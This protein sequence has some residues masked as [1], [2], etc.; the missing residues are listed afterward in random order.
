[1]QYLIRFHFSL[2]MTKSSETK[3]RFLSLRSYFLDRK[4]RPVCH[5]IGGRVRSSFLLGQWVEKLSIQF[6]AKDLDRKDVVGTSDPFLR[7]YKSNEDNRHKLIGYFTA[8]LEQL[9][10]GAKFECE[11]PNKEG[12]KHSGDRVNSKEYGQQL[13]NHESQH[14]FQP[15]EQTSENQMNGVLWAWVLKKAW[16]NINNLI[17]VDFT[18]SNG[19][20]GDPK[21][22]HYANPNSPNAYVQALRGVGEV[23]ELYDS[24]GMFPAWGF[25]ARLPPDGAISHCF[26]LNEHISNP[27]CIK[28]DGVLEAYYQTL[29]RTHADGSEYFI[30]LILTDGMFCDIDNT[31]KA[32]VA[33]SS[34]PLSIII[35]GIGDAD[36]EGMK[37][38]DGDKQRFSFQGKEAEGDIV[39]FFKFDEFEKVKNVR[40]IDEYK[41]ILAAEVLA[42]VPGQF[43]SYMER[44][45]VRPG[46]F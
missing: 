18:E 25:G 32:I 29:A 24:D 17:A 3:S 34:L 26:P 20:P 44:N 28:I 23:I 27:Y 38:L 45:K 2:T 16:T 6:C 8:S 14:E 46:Q 36:F 4:L 22:L 15:L 30:L 19:K 7:I 31:S 39:Q 42:E 12:K 40:S 33:A 35:I 37:I 13:K 43:L 41:M 21:S 5:Q 9:K 11:K 10:S 1:M